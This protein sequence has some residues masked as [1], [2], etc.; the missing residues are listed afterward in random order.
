M[1][2]SILALAVNGPGVS[3]GVPPP[4]ADPLKAAVAPSQCLAYVAWSGMADPDPKSSN[5]TEQLVAEPE[6]QKLILAIGQIAKNTVRT[7]AEK[8]QSGGGETAA[9]IFD[10]GVQL[11][12]R[13]AAAV[14]SKVE[15]FS[16]GPRGFAR[17]VLP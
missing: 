5:R 15:P 16:G 7:A 13:P 12:S 17:R 6:V 8:E 3:L 1:F 2:L 9:G 10:L 4:S 14:L 11:L